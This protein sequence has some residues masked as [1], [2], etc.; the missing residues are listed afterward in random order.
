MAELFNADKFT[1]LKAQTP[2]FSDL[3]TNFTVHPELHDLVVK[4]NEESVKTAIRNLLLTNKYERPFNPTFGGNIR[5]YLF[6]PMSPITAQGLR[7]EI[8]SLVENNEPR[9]GLLKVIV[10]P[11]VDENA[12]AIT[13]TFYL[14]NTSTEVTLNTILYRVR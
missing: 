13:I 6:E 9:A 11:Y 3:F 5:N 12:Y 7:D 10:T 8:I 2:L 4:K 1:P 14:I